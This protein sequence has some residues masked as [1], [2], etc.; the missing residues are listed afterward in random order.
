MVK[1]FIIHG[2]ARAPARSRVA[3]VPRLDLLHFRQSVN[4][5]GALVSPRVDDRLCWHR[6]P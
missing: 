6:H 1:N 2:L 4:T 5:L 3:A